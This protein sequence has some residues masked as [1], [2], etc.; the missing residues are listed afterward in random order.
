MNFS[1]RLKGSVTESLIRSLLADCGLTVVPLGIEEVIREMAELSQE[2]YLALS[3]PDSLR[4]LPDFFATN[5]DRSKSWLIEVKFRKTWTNEVRDEL[6]LKLTPQVNVWSPLY[7][8]L[9]YG[10]SPHPYD[11][12]G[13]AAWIR[14]G[15]LRIKD[16]KLHVMDKGVLKPWSESKWNSMDRIQDVFPELNDKE[17]WN[18]GVLKDML[19]VSKHLTNLK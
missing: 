15:E 1:N 17:K 4:K 2:R 5:K 11:T 14:V 18:E 7:L 3:L 10:E 8:V 6:E 13:P 9:F 12:T 16:T 19:L